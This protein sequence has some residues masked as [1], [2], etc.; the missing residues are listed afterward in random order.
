M[1]NHY[2]SSRG[3]FEDAF[4]FE[5]IRE[6]AIDIFPDRPAPVLRSRAEGG[7]DL[8]LMRWGFPPPPNVPG[9]RP[10][11]N[12]RNLTSAYWRPWLKPETRCLVPFTEF[13]EFAP[14]AA[15]RRLEVWFRVTDNRP[16]AFAGIWRPWIGVRGTKAA[17]VEGE[18]LL[19]SFLT[20]TPNDVVRPYHEKA[21]PVILIG[22]EAQLAWLSAPTAA[23]EAIAAP[24]LNEDL[25]VVE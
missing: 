14:G 3:A 25:V 7:L 10:V 22:I 11:T 9:G 5:E 6:T 1:C 15:G 4:G 8:T 13:A 20:T 12:V 18:H 17:P 2:R 16:A 21:M 24:V 23:V 19:F